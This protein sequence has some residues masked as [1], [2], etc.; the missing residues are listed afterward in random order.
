MDECGECLGSGFPAY[1]KLNLHCHVLIAQPAPYDVAFP[2][3]FYRRLVRDGDADALGRQ[4]GSLMRMG[5]L[6]NDPRLYA[7]SFK[8]FN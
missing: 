3:P 4:E 8:A 5:N 7:G 1:N 6:L 2:R